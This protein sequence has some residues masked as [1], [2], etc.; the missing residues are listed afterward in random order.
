M[1]VDNLGIIIQRWLNTYSTSQHSIRY[2]TVIRIR[3]DVLKRLSMEYIID[4]GDFP[5]TNRVIVESSIVFVSI[6]STIGLL[7][8]ATTEEFKMAYFYL[9]YMLYYSLPF[10]IAAFWAVV[11]MICANQRRKEAAVSSY[12]A[13]I[14]FTTGL[15]MLIY[16][17]S[18]ATQTILLPT[19]FMFL[20]AYQ[21]L[22]FLEF[23][24][25][26]IFITVSFFVVFCLS[27][28]KFLSKN[29][30]ILFAFV[31]MALLGGVTIMMM[32]GVRQTNY[33]AE[34]GSVFL[35]GEPDF[36]SKDIMVALRTA[37]QIVVEVNSLDE[38]YMSYAFLDEGNYHQYINLTTRANARTIKEDF[39]LKLPFQLTIDVSGKYYLV[40]KSE[41]FNGTNATY[42]I[43]V[44][45]TDSAVLTNAFFLTIISS[46]AVFG[47]S[48]SHKHEDTT[49][50]YID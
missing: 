2:N 1:V 45:Q 9:G 34:S 31:A 24:V 39:G 43:T 18:L 36:Q 4:L 48:I 41:Y 50:S 25:A 22:A 38:H 10:I 35:S 28:L 29:R 21:P 30:H 11:S 14:L 5:K 46:S 16:L 26:I 17:A 44:Y 13:V 23:F 7:I 8:G 19:S 6:F 49:P 40:M 33:L 27:K 15:M 37:D 42:S 47:I 3:L 12:L 32:F 20:T